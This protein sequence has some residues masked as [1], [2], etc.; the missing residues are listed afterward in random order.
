M[1]FKT[2]TISHD[3]RARIFWTLI[4]IFCIC[5]VTYVYAVRATINNTVTRASLES[6]SANLVAQVGDMEFDL[7]GMQ[8][9]VSLQLAYA[10]GFQDVNQ[11]TYISR[12]ASH[13]LSM[14]VTSKFVTLSR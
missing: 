4:S 14:N 11:P 6:A 13:S 8:N 5:L 10:R 7:I 12:S 3:S 2:R 9:N 1:T